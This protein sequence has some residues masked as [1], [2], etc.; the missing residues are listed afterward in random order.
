MLLFTGKVKELKLSIYGA[1]FHTCGGKSVYLELLEGQTSCTTSTKEDFDGGVTLI[2]SGDQ[3]DSCA[4][5][6]FDVQLDEL[7]FKLRSTDGDDF[8]PKT[9]VITLY[10]NVGKITTYK[11]DGMNDWVAKDVNDHIRTATKL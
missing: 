11:A 4:E 7:K 10:D 9:L 5:K 6:I 3:L 1:F 2:W 8:C